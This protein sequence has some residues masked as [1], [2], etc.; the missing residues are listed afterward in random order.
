MGP[1]EI[2]N[3]LRSGLHVQMFR[4]YAENICKS[5]K[6]FWKKADIQSILY[7][8]AE[9]AEKIVKIHKKYKLFVIFISY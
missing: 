8:R 7:L 6:C 9:T 1:S 5:S 4:K 2:K 3:G